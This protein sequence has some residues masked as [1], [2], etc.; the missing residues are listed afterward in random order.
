[1]HEFVAI[2]DQEL[3]VVSEEVVVASDGAVEEVADEDGA[4]AADHGEDAESRLDVLDAGSG[5]ETC[6]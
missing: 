4:V 1:M 5:R 2:A 6:D 3:G